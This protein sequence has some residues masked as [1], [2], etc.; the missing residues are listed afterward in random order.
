MSGVAAGGG[1]GC[2]TVVRADR[3]FLIAKHFD[4]AQKR[5]E[6]RKKA[7]R[8]LESVWNKGKHGNSIANYFV[9]KT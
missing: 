6:L 2:W 1:I 8:V 9:A 3:S 7:A 5:R 4:Q